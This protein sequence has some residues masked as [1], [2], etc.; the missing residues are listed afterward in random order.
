MESNSEGVNE[1]MSD[2]I[3]DNSSMYIHTMETNKNIRGKWE[4][5]DI[6]HSD[7]TNDGELKLDC[8]GR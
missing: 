3:Y 2:N 6:H 5:Q 7:L 8:G 4:K 1:T